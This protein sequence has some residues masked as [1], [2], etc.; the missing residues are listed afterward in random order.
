MDGDISCPVPSIPEATSAG[1][2][3]FLPMIRY[4]R[5]ISKAYTSLYS[6]GVSSNPSSYYLEVI[7][8]LDTELE[9]WRQS[10][11]DTGFRPGGLCRPHSLL[12]PR[13]RSV[14]LAFHYF[15]H[16]FLF[17]LCRTALHYQTSSNDESAAQTQSLCKQK[18]LH[19]ARA[20]L[21]LTS[22]VDVEPY[23]HLG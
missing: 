15:Y 7:E 20:V 11:P 23:T 4:A 18:I 5:L 6:V 14:A 8:Q 10:L 21:E 2:A 12:E 9:Q 17:T 16:S 13:S 3:W 22:L 19:S 1:F